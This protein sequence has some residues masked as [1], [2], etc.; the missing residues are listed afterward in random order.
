MFSFTTLQD[1]PSHLLT[2]LVLAFIASIPNHTIRYS[3]LGVIVTL[4]VL[5]VIQLNPRN[6][7]ELTKEM[8][9]LL[10]AI[11][12]ASLIKCRI[13]HSER[14]RF[15]WTNYRAISNAIA[16]CAKCV[17]SIRNAVESWTEPQCSIAQLVVE[18]EHQRKVADDIGD[19]QFILAASQTPKCLGVYVYRQ[20][21]QTLL[22][23]PV[24]SEIFTIPNTQ[25]DGEQP[26]SRERDQERSLAKF[27]WCIGM[28]GSIYL[29]KLGGKWNMTIA[30]QVRAVNL[31]ILRRKASAAPRMER[32]RTSRINLLTLGLQPRRAREKILSTCVDCQTAL[33][34]VEN[35][36]P[37]E[38]HWI[39]AVIGTNHEH[40]MDLGSPLWAPVWTVKRR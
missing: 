17:K 35:K 11:N 2:S 25:C 24:N 7:F 37:V 3:A 15:N 21:Q 36:M 20:Y 4:S 8:L 22:F 39:L 40:Q 32:Y 33:T 19:T 9:E 6:Y 18:A 27:N 26:A 34:S 5:C 28:L 10:E 29:S 16:G 31:V 30:N 13:L 38:N 14:L 23:H 12:T 1:P